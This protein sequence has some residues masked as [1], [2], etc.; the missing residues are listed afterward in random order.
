[1]KFEL[2]KDLPASDYHKIEAFS[3]STAKICLRSAAHFVAS[4]ETVREPSDA[5]K[6][7]TAVHTAILEPHLFDSEIAIMPKFDKRTKAGKEGAEQFATDNMDKTV[8]DFYQGEKVKAMA[9]SVRSHEFFKSYVKDGDAEATMLWGQYAVQCKARVDYI[10]GGTIFDV[11]TCQDASPAGFSKQVASFGYHLQAA[12]YA[13][14]YKRVCGEPLDRFV[15]IA[16]ESSYPH[17]V[18]IYT[19]GSESLK[20]GQV[21]LGKAARVYAYALSEK[22]QQT[23]GNRVTE[24]DI[25]SW[26]MPVPFEGK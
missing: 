17:M 18:G 5:M 26:A 14:G 16:V 8:I 21:E 20:A 23:Y 13:M 24:I 19:L 10:A 3:A 15:F 4:R 12:H 11:K 7:G 9:D 22:P 6:M 25:P 2:I 1:M